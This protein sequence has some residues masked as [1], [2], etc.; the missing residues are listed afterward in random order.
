M[1]VVIVRKVSERIKRLILRKFPRD[2]KVVMVPSEELNKEL[3]D[4]ETIIPEHHIIDGPLLDRARHLKLVQTAAGYDNVMVDEC[5]K[6]G[7]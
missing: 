2:W 7:V 1:N 5:T 3:E 4:V 6:R